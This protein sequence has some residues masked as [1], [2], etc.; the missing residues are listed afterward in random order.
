MW[1]LVAGL[2]CPGSSDLQRFDVDLSNRWRAEVVEL[3]R[4]LMKC[5]ME[6]TVV[7]GNVA[8]DFVVRIY[9][10]K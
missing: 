4:P 8:T 10:V 1:V 9:F 2:F 3:R 5:V 7:Y 6:G